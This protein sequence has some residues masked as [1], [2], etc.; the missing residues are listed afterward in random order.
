MS[1]DAP[2]PAWDTG[3]RGAYAGRNNVMTAV[4]STK[5]NG[6]VVQTVFKNTNLALRNVIIE[7]V[8]EGAAFATIT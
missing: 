8:P 7:V 2:T 3:N 1:L 5:C 6:V 4:L